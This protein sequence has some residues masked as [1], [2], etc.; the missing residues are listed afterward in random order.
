MKA[1]WVG[2]ELR[3]LRSIGQEA[4]IDSR[5]DFASVYS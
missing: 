5:A 3:F 1:N 2:E 4:L